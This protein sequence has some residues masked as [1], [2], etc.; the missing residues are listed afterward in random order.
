M[1]TPAAGC[2]MR[3]VYFSVRSAGNTACYFI[4]IYFTLHRTVVKKITLCENRLCSE[5]SLE[6]RPKISTHAQNNKVFLSYSD[7]DYSDV[8]YFPVA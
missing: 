4:V 7:V 8:E 6:R 2:Q 1:P 3:R 5:S